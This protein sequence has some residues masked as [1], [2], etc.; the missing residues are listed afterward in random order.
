MRNAIPESSSSEFESVCLKLLDNGWLKFVLHGL[1][2]EVLVEET[3]SAA[4]C[5]LLV[6]VV[7][8]LKV[9]NDTAAHV[10][11]VLAGANAGKQVRA[12]LLV[13]VSTES[14]AGC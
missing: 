12:C 10:C 3:G 7:N 9:A 1:A 2:A 11:V 5:V 4:K 13:E 8:F 14:P 6:L